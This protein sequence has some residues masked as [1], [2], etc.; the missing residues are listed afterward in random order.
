MLYAVS[1]INTVTFALFGID[2]RKAVKHRKR[3]L[4]TY[5][6]MLTFLG[7]TAGATIR[8]FAFRHKISKQSFLLKQV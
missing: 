6:L 5:L 8:M 2:K 3:I 7:G 1:I 4:E